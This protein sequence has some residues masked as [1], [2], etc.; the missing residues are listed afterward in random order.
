M[1]A[2]VTSR[3]VEVED[4]PPAGVIRWLI[5]CDE[6]GIGGSPYYGFG[7]LWM[8]WQRRGNFSAL[9]RRLRAEHNYEHEIKW[10]KVSDAN[11]GFYKALVEEFFKSSYLF[12]HCLV[13]CNA[14]VDLEQHGRDRDL[15]RRKHFT[16]LLT[17]KIRRCLR[18][19]P[20]RKQTF[21]IWVDPIHS[22]YAKADEAV[23]PN[24]IIYSLVKVGRF[25]HLEAIRQTGRLRMQ[26]LAF[27]RDIEDPARR[28]RDDGL[29][30][31][32][33]PD[34]V[35]L[36]FGGHVIDGFAGPIKVSRDQ[37]ANHHIFCMYALTSR[38]LAAILD[39]GAPAVDPE[40]LKFGDHALLITNVGA[41]IERMLAAAKRSGVQRL[42]AGL[43]EYIDTE[44]YHGVV[45][46][47]RKAA[48]YAT[49]SEWRMVVPPSASDTFWFD[50]GQS[51]ED[52]S[53]LALVAA[54]N[55]QLRLSVSPGGP[56]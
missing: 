49:E 5:S 25:E 54:L 35:T 26:R 40:N 22:R 12:F 14:D 3:R 4:E 30:V 20:K 9:I 34:Q 32:Y 7:T 39:A 47:F 46:P 18:A 17:D 53:V 52:I 1:V 27:Y 45:G 15:A 51:L 55:S 43:V 2:N 31:L 56:S 38:R 50:C 44:T 42:W 16:M 11:L 19:Y 6:S 37:D 28:D 10:T 33:Q 29:T 24:T 8:G 41:F 23:D 21:R 48:K 36:T 13:V